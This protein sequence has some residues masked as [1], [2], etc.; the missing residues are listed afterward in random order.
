MKQR[1]CPEYIGDY[2]SKIITVLVKARM[3][4]VEFY[5]AVKKNGQD[6]FRLVIEMQAYSHFYLSLKLFEDM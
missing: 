4:Y 3:I 6:N 2:S 1:L 5:W